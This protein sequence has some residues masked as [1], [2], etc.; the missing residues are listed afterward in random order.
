[1]TISDGS[2]AMIFINYRKCGIEN[3]TSRNCLTVKRVTKLS[4]LQLPFITV[5][6]VCVRRF[7][8]KFPARETKLIAHMFLSAY[9]HTKILARVFPFF[10]WVSKIRVII[11]VFS[12]LPFRNRQSI[13]R[14]LPTKTCR[15]AL[16]TRAIDRN[17]RKGSLCVQR[18][19]APLYN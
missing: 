3:C 12:R 17:H 7:F 6:R 10:K 11:Y 18:H 15:N 2:S 19:N 8:S 16:F 9:V 5:E 14:Q 4:K 1:M 13:I